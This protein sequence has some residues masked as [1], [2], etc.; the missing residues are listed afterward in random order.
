MSA[1]R[2]A[3]GEI[4]VEKARKKNPE[5]LLKWQDILALGFSTGLFLKPLKLTEGLILLD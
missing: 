4:G 2:A 5:T 3:V 1:V